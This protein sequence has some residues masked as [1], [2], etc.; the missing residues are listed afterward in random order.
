MTLGYLSVQLSPVRVA[1]ASGRRH[2]RVLDATAAR[3]KDLPSTLHTTHR[4]FLIG[5]N[6]KDLSQSAA[7]RLVGNVQRRRSPA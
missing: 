5:A 3:F 4:K 6:D 2:M 1:A 7:A